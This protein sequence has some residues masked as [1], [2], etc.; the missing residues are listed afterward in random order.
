MSRRPAKPADRMA[1]GTELIRQWL[2]ASPFVAHLG[3]S[4]DK[5]DPD[6]AVL[7][8]PFRPEHVTI[9]DIVHG[10]ALSALIDTAATAAAW[11]GAE[12]SGEIRGTTVGLT[13]S[14]VGPARSQDVTATARVSRR[15]RTLVF[16]DVEGTAADGT[17]V[18]KALVTYKLG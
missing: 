1:S 2:D 3:I 16:I 5:L 10:G 12:A 18:A 17:L 13:V 9:A 14:F 7:T 8:L 6:L 4:V 11:A 15:G